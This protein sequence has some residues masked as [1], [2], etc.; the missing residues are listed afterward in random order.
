[1]KKHSLILRHQMLVMNQQH[2]I[3]LF[4]NK[5]ISSNT[6]RATVIMKISLCT[7]HEEQE[8]ILQ[9]LVRK[10]GHQMVNISTKYAIF[11]HVPKAMIGSEIHLLN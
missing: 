1:M 7:H 9:R 11:G 6:V 10:F 2:F 5:E 4:K 3:I 8:H